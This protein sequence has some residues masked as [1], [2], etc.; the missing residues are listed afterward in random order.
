MEGLLCKSHLFSFIAR[1]AHSVHAGSLMGCC[2]PS[3]TTVKY[4]VIGW[5]WQKLHHSILSTSGTDFLVI[6]VHHS[7]THILSDSE[8]VFY[9]DLGVVL[10][11]SVNLNFQRDLE[12]VCIHIQILA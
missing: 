7:D 10:C 1:S 5:D 9:R 11:E 3:S 8:R 4:P 12:L 6:A 2:S